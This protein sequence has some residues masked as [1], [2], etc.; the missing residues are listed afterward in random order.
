MTAKE[1]ENIIQD[2]FKDVDYNFL[3]AMIERRT[4]DAVKD[5]DQKGLDFIAD[6]NRKRAQNLHKALEAAGYYE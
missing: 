2:T 4:W 3:L 5:F 6:L 1:F